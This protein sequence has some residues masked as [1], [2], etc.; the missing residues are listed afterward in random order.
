MIL[1]IDIGL[2]LYFNQ[3]TYGIEQV[4]FGVPTECVMLGEMSATLPL[5]S[6]LFPLE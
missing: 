3:N 5:N 6:S 1:S 2:L 4:G